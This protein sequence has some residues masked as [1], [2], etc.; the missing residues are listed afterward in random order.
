MPDPSL[1]SSEAAARIMSRRSMLTDAARLAGAAVATATLGTII[2]RAARGSQQ[3][4]LGGPDTISLPFTY[5][6]EKIA[7]IQQATDAFNR[8]GVK[9]GDKRIVVQL[10]PR[11]SVD[12]LQKILAGELHPVAW[13]PASTLELNQLTIGWNDAHAGAPILEM[14]GDLAPRSLVSSPL[15]LLAWQERAALLQQQFG[16]LDWPALHSALTAKHGWADIAGGNSAWG[17]V[18]FGQTRPDRSNSGL[19]TL[20]LLAM[21][22]AGQNHPLS[23][24]DAHTPAFVQFMRDVEDAVTQFGASSGTFL[25]CVTNYGPASFD[26]VTTYE[27]LALGKLSGGTSGRA[28][29]LF[30]PNPTLICD[31]PFAIVHGASAEQTAAAKVFRDDLLATEQQRLALAHGF[32]PANSAVHLSDSSVQGNL[33]AQSLPGVQAKLQSVIAPAP[34]GDVVN[35]LIDEWRQFY[36]DSPTT[37]GC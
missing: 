19:L 20:T 13:S 1:S 34:D 21:S 33:F 7:W 12:A 37:P 22:V 27:Q 6:T 5:S 29:A 25:D 14:G 8:R 36:Q 4:T 9:L 10:D 17:P 3:V 26:I 15:V 18:K 2:V 24:A 31:H 32:R 23:V 16:K 30:Y 35:A 28:L 11:G